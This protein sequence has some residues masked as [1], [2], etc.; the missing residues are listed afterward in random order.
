MILS[1][2]T[3]FF[4]FF[5]NKFCKLPPKQ[6]YFG[7]YTFHTCQPARAANSLLKRTEKRTVPRTARE[8][9]G[10]PL[11]R[12]TTAG[13]NRRPPL[14]GS[15][16]R[17]QRPHP[18][19]GALSAARRRSGLGKLAP[20]HPRPSHVQAPPAAAPSPWRPVPTS[21]PPAVGRGRGAAPQSRGGL[22][23][24]SRQSRTG[25]AEPGRPGTQGAGED[26]EVRKAEISWILGG[27][28]SLA[29]GVLTLH[30]AEGPDPQR[31]P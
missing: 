28:P 23:F 15:R 1:N 21:P 18:A 24:C 9:M 7:G 10:W 30:F 11:I 17:P 13:S 16:P 22:G 20:P 31:I 8:A 12:G 25:A 29:P 26:E 19:K 3:A 2:E 6:P 4:F 14:L 5:P 27:G